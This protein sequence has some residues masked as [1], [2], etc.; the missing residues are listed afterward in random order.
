MQSIGLCLA[1]ENPLMDKSTS[2]ER[3]QPN[4]NSTG[5]WQ[6]AI[7]G[8]SRREKVECTHP[9][10]D[11]RAVLPCLGVRRSTHARDGKCSRRPSPGRNPRS[12]T[13]LYCMTLLC[14]MAE[15]WISASSGAAS[16]RRGRDS[17]LDPRDCSNWR[18]RV[19]LPSFVEAHT[20]LDKALT[21]H[22]TD[23]T[24]ARCLRPSIS[25]AGFNAA[26]AFRTSMSAPA[27]M[28]LKFVAAGTTLVR[29]HVDVNTGIG[30]TGVE[31]LLAL[32]EALKPILDLQIVALA[33]TISGIRG[34]ENKSLVEAALSMG[35]DVMGGCPIVDGDPR[36]HID[37]VFELAE[38]LACQSI[39]MSTNQM[40]LGTSACPIL[41]SAP[42][43]WASRDACIAGHCC[44]LAAVGH[45]EPRAPSSLLRRRDNHRDL[46]LRQSVPTG[47]W[48]RGRH[49]PR[50]DTRS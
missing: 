24:A 38:R 26:L 43:C 2:P 1:A 44:S 42:E 17:M 33:T 7:S 50:P 48:R 13:I 15:W 45:A 49:S 47:T 37:D 29:T 6:P 18:G 9:A 34:A 3:A 46:A 32:R 11:V 39:C 22:L 27:T 35:V 5:P 36:A 21:V 30:L 16:R 8:V 23:N 41:P 25:W 12:T 28:A 10:S 14:S 4:V 40:R 20:H 31:A 19:V